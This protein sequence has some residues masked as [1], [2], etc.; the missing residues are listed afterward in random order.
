MIIYF[1]I[2]VKYKR[3]YEWAQPTH[4]SENNND[5]LPGTRGCWYKSLAHGKS[6]PAFHGMRHPRALCRVHYKRAR[7]RA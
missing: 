1:S 4:A 5:N 7:L 6:I 2:L 3:G